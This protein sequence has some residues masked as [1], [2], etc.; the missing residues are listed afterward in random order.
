[1]RS[2][3]AVI[4]PGVVFVGSAGMRFAAVNEYVTEPSAFVVGV[5]LLQPRKNRP[6]VVE[7]SNRGEPPRHCVGLASVND[8][9]WNACPSRPVM[10]A[11][12]AEL[13]CG[14][15]GVQFFTRCSTP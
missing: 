6:I 10:S 2:D 5:T 8:A 1:M 3:T 13:N 11:P 4:V 15:P 14:L 7:M 12:A 9:D